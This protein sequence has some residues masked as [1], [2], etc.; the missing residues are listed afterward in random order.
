MKKSKSFRIRIGIFYL[1]GD[2]IFWGFIP[3]LFLSFFK[4]KKKKENNFDIFIK[5]GR[6]YDIQG[7]ILF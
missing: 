3:M 7:F 4:N 5:K 6:V 2:A 1:K